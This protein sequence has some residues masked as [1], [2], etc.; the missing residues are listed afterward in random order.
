MYK[1]CNLQHPQYGNVVLIERAEEG[2]EKPFFAVQAALKSRRLWRESG[3]DKV[4]FLIDGEI[5]SIK[6][7]E[8]WARQEYKS[9]PK[10][11]WCIKI[12]HGDVFTHALCGIDVFCSQSCADKDYQEKMR[13]GEEIEYL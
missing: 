5:M 13:N 7:I 11:P 6:E 4:R 2:I 3:I 9:L 8:A 12:L 1:I 10:C